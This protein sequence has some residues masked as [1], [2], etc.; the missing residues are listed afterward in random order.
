MPSLEVSVASDEPLKM[1]PSRGLGVHSES[2][3][4]WTLD[5]DKRRL[6]KQHSDLGPDLAWYWYWV[7]VCWLLPILAVLGWKEQS[8]RLLPAASS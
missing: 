7:W 6:R 8:V 5:A 4:W 3:L 2:G 1:G